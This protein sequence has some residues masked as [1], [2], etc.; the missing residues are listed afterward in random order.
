MLLIYTPEKIRKPKG[1]L[2][3]AGGVD[4]QHRAVERGL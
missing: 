4:K 1:F 2:M 3:F